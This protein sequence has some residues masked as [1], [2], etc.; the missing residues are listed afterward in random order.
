[1]SSRPIT[2]FDI[3]SERVCFEYRS[4]L[5]RREHWIAVYF[6]EN[7]RGEFMDSYGLNPEF[8]NFDSFMNE[9]ETMW[10]CNSKPIQHPLSAVCGH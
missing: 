1:M 7:K 4:K 10:S 2:C 3:L 5:K 9:N 8:Y 6:D